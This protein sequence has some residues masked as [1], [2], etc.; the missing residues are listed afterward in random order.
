MSTGP[1]RQAA[2]FQ[3]VRGDTCQ[4]TSQITLKQGKANKKFPMAKTPWEPHH[5]ALIDR[6]ARMRVQSTRQ[7]NKGRSNCQEMPYRIGIIISIE[8]KK[9]FILAYYFR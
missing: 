4:R 9:L 1:D 3:Q 6:R 8:L 7:A 2:V 5:Q